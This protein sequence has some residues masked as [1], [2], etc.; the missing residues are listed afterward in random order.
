MLS[1][2]KCE[3]YTKCKQH[4]YKARILQYNNLFVIF[5]LELQFHSLLDCK[6]NN[7]NQGEHG[8]SDTSDL[9]IIIKY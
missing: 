8:N 6:L 5:R 9:F 3:A 2:C 7:F 4:E 1:N